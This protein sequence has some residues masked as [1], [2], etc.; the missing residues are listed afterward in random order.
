[1]DESEQAEAM[2]GA[3]ASAQMGLSMF[4]S[5]M[6]GF[7]KQFSFDPHLMQN[8]SEK[9]APCLLKYGG[10][11]PSFLQPYKEEI[12]AVS[13]LGVLGFA[14]YQQIKELKSLDNAKEVEHEKI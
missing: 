2:A 5:I 3:I 1:M 7:H 14:S 10:E 6:K 11:L 13:G 4:E 8:A 12:C 9:I